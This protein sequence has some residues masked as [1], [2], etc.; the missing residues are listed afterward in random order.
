MMGEIA[1]AT[2]EGVFCEDCGEYLGEG[3]GYP[4]RCPECQNDQP[5]TTTKNGQPICR[6]SKVNC[7]ECNKLVKKGQGLKDHLIDVHNKW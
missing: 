2:L 7:P 1:E 4:R 6:P 3:C 5:Q